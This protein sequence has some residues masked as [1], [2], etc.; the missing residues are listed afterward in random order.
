MFLFH[1]PKLFTPYLLDTL[2]SAPHHHHHLLIRI[3]SKVAVCSTFCEINLSECQGQSVSEILVSVETSSKYIGIWSFPPYFFSFC[4]FVITHCLKLSRQCQVC[5]PN[6]SLS[7]ALFF[8]LYPNA[9]PWLP[10]V[11]HGVCTFSTCTWGHCSPVSNWAV[12]LNN[13]LFESSISQSQKCVFVLDL[14]L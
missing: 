8:P 5:L 10:L 6:D 11:C 2:L 13:I 3:R 14:S 7:V 1:Q 4:H 9:L 12:P